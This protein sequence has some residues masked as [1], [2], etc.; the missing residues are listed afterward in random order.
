MKRQFVMKLRAM[1][2]AQGIGVNALQKILGTGPSQVQRLLDPEDAGVSLK[3]IVRLLAVFGAEG[4]IAVEQK[5][6]KERVA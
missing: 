5:R 4:Q 1:M 6:S 2:K 3:S